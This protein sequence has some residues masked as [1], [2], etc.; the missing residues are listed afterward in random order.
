MGL[1][2]LGFSFNTPRNMEPMIATYKKHVSN[3]DPRPVCK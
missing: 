1:G 3:A 2:A